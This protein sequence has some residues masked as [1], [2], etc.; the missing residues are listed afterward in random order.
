MTTPDEA[1]HAERHRAR[2]ARK[3]EII[4]AKIAQ[5]D[6]DQGVL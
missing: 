2:M 3:K 4:D 6:R 1:A 5:A